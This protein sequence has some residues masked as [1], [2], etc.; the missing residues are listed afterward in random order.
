MLRSKFKIAGVALL[1]STGMYFTAC[2]SKPKEEPKVETAPVET[3]QP[4]APVEIASD[5]ALTTG[6]KDAT[7]DFPGVKADVND[8]VVTLTGSVER[9]RLQTLMQSLQSLK[10]KKV[11]NQLTIK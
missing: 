10:P 1:M 2:K 7:K 8:G 6:V 3:T 5:D 11:I 4:A 9:S